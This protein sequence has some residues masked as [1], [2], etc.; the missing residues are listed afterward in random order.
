[1]ID[2]SLCDKGSV[3]NQSNCECECDKLCDVGE[4]LD[5]ESCKCR[6]ELFGKLV[7]ECIE[8]AEEV[9]LI[10]ITLAD[11]E[12]VCKSYCTIY[13]VLIAIISPIVIG[14]GTYFVYYRYMNRDR[15]MKYDYAY[16]TTI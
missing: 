9:E 2:K 15:Y 1:M 6:K 3:W 10:K 12:N 16:Q 7:E 14:I 5:Y 8:N 13:V 4:Y 11:H